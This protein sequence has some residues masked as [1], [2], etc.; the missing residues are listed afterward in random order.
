[1]ITRT[2]PILAALAAVL[3][4]AQASSALARDCPVVPVPDFSASIDW[5][6]P[7]LIE[8]VASDDLPASG[9]GRRGFP[10]ADRRKLGSTESSLLVRT[11]LIVSE[12]DADR[13][14]FALSEL[15][16][17]IVAGPVKVYVASELDS[18]SC[19]YRVTLAHEDRHVEVFRD[20][21]DALLD[22]LQGDM[23]APSLRQSIPGKD[24]KLPGERLS[25]A[26]NVVGGDARRKGGLEEARRSL[27]VS[28][29][30]A[31]EVV[32]DRRADQPGGVVESELVKREIDKA[33]E[34]AEPRA[35]SAERGGR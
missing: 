21:A 30:R 26:I 17:Q 10:G 13:G 22:Q 1:M 4:L 11:S 3:V 15:D 12:L 16:V 14:C 8:N 33:D 31:G 2:V 34:A 6:E 5:L 18:D 29:E 20:A 27:P 28:V 19:P 35:R 25:Q 23:A 9:N 7:E 32:E 24:I